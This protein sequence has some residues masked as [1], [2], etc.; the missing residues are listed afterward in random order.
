MVNHVAVIESHPIQR[1]LLRSLALYIN[2]SKHPD[3]SIGRK[4]GRER[5]QIITKKKEK[6]FLKKVHI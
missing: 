3:I 5:K 6:K 4:K 1:G 2:Q